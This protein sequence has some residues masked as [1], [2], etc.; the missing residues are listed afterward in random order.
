MTQLVAMVHNRRPAMDSKVGMSSNNLPMDNR[1]EHTNNK[2]VMNSSN[3][4]MDNGMEDIAH[5]RPKLLRV[6]N[7]KRTQAATMAMSRATM[8]MVCLF[9]LSKSSC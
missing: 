3:P 7:H 1:K 9:H 4:A 6:H 2:V 5:R 8:H